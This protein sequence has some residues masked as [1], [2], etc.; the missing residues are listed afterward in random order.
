MT[1][2][3][4]AYQST[5]RR[6]QVAIPCLFAVIAIFAAGTTAIVRFVDGRDLET[7]F[8]SLGGV[9]VLLLGAILLTTF[10]VHRWTVQQREVDIHERPR[11]PLMGLSRRTIVPFSD[12]AALRHVE[13]GLD[14][15]IEMTARDGRRFRLSQA[16]K[17]GSRDF[18]QRDPDA[19]LSAFVASIRVAAE[20]AGHVLPETS[21]GLS[22]WNSAGGLAFLILM[23]ATSLLISGLVAWAL[24]LGMTIGPR[25]RGG[26][27]LAILLLLPL[28]AGYLLFKSWKRRVAVRASAATHR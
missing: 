5:Y 12:I 23:F 18:A 2:G 19:D 1:P 26:E 4:C 25:P 10:R 17:G 16:M 7:A 8:F 3:D 15:L 20:R 6:S 11:V 28:G 14:Y 24:W 9:T 21:E 22:F 13:S 27:A